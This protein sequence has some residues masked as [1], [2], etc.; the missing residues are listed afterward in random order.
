MDRQL[1]YGS[2]RRVG[3]ER[4]GSRTGPRIAAFGHHQPARVVDNAEL[5]TMV[6]TT[7]EWIR[8]RVGIACRHLAG[9][10]E[11]VA[12]M[13]VAAGG[14]ALA[15]GGLAPGEI[16][17][18]I[19]A[20]SSQETQIPG[21]AAGV[22][23]RLGI[24]APG[25]YD[26]NAGCAG[27]SYALAAAADALRAGSARNALIIGAEKMSAWLDWQ[28]RTTCV[29]FADG[30]GAA[31]VTERER[32]AAWIG[33]VVWGSAGEHAERITVRSR[34]SFFAQDGQ[35]VYRW[36]TSLAPVALEACRRAGIAPHDLAAF[37]PHQANLR[38]IRSLARQLGAPRALVA[39]DIVTSGNTAAASIP[40]ALSRMAERGE[41]RSGDPV[42]LLGFG[43]G[44]TYG[45]QVITAP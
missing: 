15:A 1:P 16:D 4:R 28:D 39:E 17:L 33:P 29:I 5:A 45:A 26:V 37:V 25:A 35:A 14:K 19:V 18:V 42:L 31:V 43:H 20:T 38:I 40:L 11:S 44:L 8:S 22:A 23:H 36:A 24:A 3:T 10:D 13:A 32:P 21:A 7:D 30:A 9:P 27:F 2:S 6:D 34:D 41:L 12:D